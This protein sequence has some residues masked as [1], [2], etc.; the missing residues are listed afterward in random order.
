MYIKTKEQKE[1]LFKIIEYCKQELYELI[2]NENNVLLLKDKNVYKLQ[3]IEYD[4]QL[5]INSSL[6]PISR[7]AVEP[8]IVFKAVCSYFKLKEHQILLRTKKMEICRPRQILQYFYKKIY[9]WSNQKIATKTGLKN[10]ATILSNVRGIKHELTYNKELQKQ[11][12]Q[13]EQLIS[14]M[15]NSNN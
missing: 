2:I 4:Y 14:K 11:I 1:I 5:L 8:I 15:S 9:K 13:I 12:I 7:C 6:H 10:Q 3:L